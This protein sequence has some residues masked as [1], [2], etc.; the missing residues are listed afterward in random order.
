MSL[1]GR[2]MLQQYENT[3]I[4]KCIFNLAAQFV[5]MLVCQDFQRSRLCYPSSISR[6][7]SVVLFK[8]FLI[9]N[10]KLNQIAGTIG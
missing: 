8:L 1:V 9:I 3:E 10:T 7:S 4:L 6:G 5:R 2:R